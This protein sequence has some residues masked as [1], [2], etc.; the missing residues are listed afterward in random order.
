MRVVL[1]GET[2][3]GK[4]SLFN[5]LLRRKVSVVGNL[6][7]LTCD[8]IHERM[9]N[10]VLIDSPG[11]SCIENLKKLHDMQFDMI[12]F[13]IDGSVGWNNHRFFK[14]CCEIFSNKKI[15]LI[16]NKCDQED[17]ENLKRGNITTFYTSLKRD[18]TIVELKKYLLKFGEKTN[19]ADDYEWAVIGRSNVGKST[20]LNALFES[21]NF[22]VKDE[23]GTTREVHG[24]DIDYRGRKI[25]LLDTPGYRNKNRLNNLEK[26]S[27]Y[28]LERL[29]LNE[30]VSTVLVVFDLS[31]GVGHTDLFLMQ[32]VF[33]SGKGLVVA[34]N[35]SDLSNQN[36]IKKF[37]EYI[38][39]CFFD[40]ECIEVSAK[41]RVG[42]KRIL[43]ALNEVEKKWNLEVSTSDLNKWLYKTR[44]QE[45]TQSVSAKYITQFRS[46]PPKFGLFCKRRLSTSI[47]R[48]LLKSL[49]RHIGASGVPI[50]MIEKVES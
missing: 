34:L 25:K 32:K 7:N 50:E 6:Q 45:L 37:K 41:N 35:K 49:S 38:Q 23:I 26:A 11:I 16:I 48:F 43:S 18:E 4:S 3:V 20:L 31:F 10:I 22:L 8:F 17:K 12:C 44:T 27:Q 36:D 14:E 19:A 9:E 46:K 30:K 42:I 28:R 29:F 1:V 39:K 24:R 47:H 15:I 21:S 2:N 13:V 33:K 40:V 5:R